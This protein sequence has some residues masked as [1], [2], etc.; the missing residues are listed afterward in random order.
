[1]ALQT[2]RVTNAQQ[3][4]STSHSA[5]V[6]F[7]TRCAA[8][9]CP[10]KFS[11]LPGTKQHPQARAHHCVTGLGA[12]WLAS[13]QKT[14]GIQSSLLTCAPCSFRMCQNMVNRSIPVIREYKVVPVNSAQGRPV[15]DL[16]KFR[17]YMQTAVR[18]NSSGEQ[19]ISFNAVIAKF[20]QLIRYVE[21]ERPSPTI[22]RTAAGRYVERDSYY[23]DTDSPEPNVDAPSCGFLPNMTP[24][25]STISACH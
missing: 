3:A 1:M 12:L 10:F 5:Q 19:R 18:T 22:P 15:V 14:A 11:R 6:Y 17:A 23:D 9:Y 7:R 2:H 13:E 21:D 16:V 4:V 24:G 20:L 8:H 25:A